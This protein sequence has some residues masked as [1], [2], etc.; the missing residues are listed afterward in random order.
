MTDED[1]FYRID[2]GFLNDGRH[3]EDR[4]DMILPGL[5]YM[6]ADLGLFA[7]LSL[8]LWS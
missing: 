5:F 8:A 4:Y 7:W 2:V 6:D 3:F 1:F